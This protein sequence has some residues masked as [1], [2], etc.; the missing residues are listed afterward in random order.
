M[1]SL[2]FLKES[3]DYKKVVMVWSGSRTYYP[4][5][6]KGFIEIIKVSVAPN[7]G[8]YYIPSLEEW[9]MG[10]VGDTKPLETIRFREVGNNIFLG[11]LIFSEDIACSVSKKITLK[12]GWMIQFYP[13]EIIAHSLIKDNKN[14]YILNRRILEERSVWGTY[15]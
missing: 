9:M 15:S 2:P 10:L 5:Y 13:D 3:H 14:Q 1:T 4:N 8:I 7:P 11:R 12:R 6:R